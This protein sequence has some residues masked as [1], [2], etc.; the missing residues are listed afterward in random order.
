MICSSS[1]VVFVINRLLHCAT[2]ALKAV[3]WRRSGYERGMAILA[4]LSTLP[5]LTNASR[6]F[7]MACRCLDRIAARH[8]TFLAYRDSKE[9]TP[10][11]PRRVSS[12]VSVN[13]LI[14]FPD[15]S[16][17]LKFLNW[18]SPEESPVCTNLRTASLYAAILEAVRESRTA[19]SVRPSRDGT[20]NT[21]SNLSNRF[22]A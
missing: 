3:E 6:Q 15:A 18:R 8:H 10:A 5:P 21:R 13:N 12:F 1:H 20:T 7:A 14:E 11:C 2:F 4:T 9:R 22:A 17:N 16:F 19:T